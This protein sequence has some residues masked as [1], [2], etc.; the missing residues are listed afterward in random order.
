MKYYDLLTYETK[1]GRVDFNVD[2]KYILEN[3]YGVWNNRIIQ[4]VFQFSFV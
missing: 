1:L 2:L 3:L 4:F